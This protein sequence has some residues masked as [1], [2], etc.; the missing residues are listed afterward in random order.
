MQIA[1][2]GLHLVIGSQ[3]LLMFDHYSL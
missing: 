1:V 2:I 3:N